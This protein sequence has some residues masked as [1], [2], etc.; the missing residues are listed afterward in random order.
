MNVDLRDA[1]LATGTAHLLSVSGMHLAILVFVASLVLSSMGFR[2]TRRL[3]VI[4]AIS[5]L[6]VLVTGGRPPVLRAALLVSVLLLA[7][8]FRRTSQPINTLSAAAI[9]LMVVN[10]MN[11]FSV[12]VHLSFLAVATL[13]TAGKMMLP[14]TPASDFGTATVGEL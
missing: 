11:V 12:G 9:I 10:P 1:L 13:M 2:P 7:H 3:I 14:Q 8:C 6:Y 5:T 4:I